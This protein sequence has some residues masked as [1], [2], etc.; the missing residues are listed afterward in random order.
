MASFPDFSLILKILDL[1][2]ASY[3]ILEKNLDILKTIYKGLE[4]SIVPSKTTQRMLAT[5]LEKYTIPKISPE[6]MDYI[7]RMTLRSLVG[8]PLVPIGTKNKNGIRELEGSISWL[9]EEKIDVTEFI[10]KMREAE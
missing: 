10:R 5:S 6:M 2:E 4:E 3:Y 8:L 1:R 7:S 9:T